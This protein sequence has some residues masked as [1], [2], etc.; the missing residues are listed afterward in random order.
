MNV[1]CRPLAVHDPVQQVRIPTWLLYPTHA[2]ERLERFGMYSLEVAPAAEIAGDQLPLV[3][4]SHGTGGTPWAYRG[5]AAHLVRHGFVVA[6][7]E[8]PGNTRRDDAL[9]H[10]VVNL[11]NRPR[12]VRVVIDAALADPDL[13]PRI[14]HHRIAIA[15]HSMGG[16][17]ALAVLGGRA[18]TLPTQTPEGRPLPVATDADPR[19]RAAI[20]LAP[21]IDWFG[22]DDA[23][24]AV[25]APIFVRTGERDQL[26]SASRVR[27]VLRS[28][29][30][31]AAIDHADVPNAGHFGF[32][33]PF[34]PDMQ[35]PDL[36]PSQDPPG[37]DRPA[38]QT[39]LHAEIASFLSSALPR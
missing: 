24:A 26:A 29:A 38:Y 23:L 28:H 15:G 8:H 16:Y 13:G 30:A 2:P 21:A 14:A 35:R 31:P 7:L 18:V 20:L 4:I 5:L 12:H 32:M 1:G 25:T 39:V 11:T 17:T 6:M 22:S 36:P 37:F 34:P 27:W 33:S 10:T 9:A 3:V 19:V